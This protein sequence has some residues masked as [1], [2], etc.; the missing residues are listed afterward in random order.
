M[1]A[2]LSGDLDK[3]GGPGILGCLR[4]N[5]SPHGQGE[6]FVRGLAQQAEASPMMTAEKGRLTGC[7]GI[8]MH[9]ADLRHFARFFRLLGMIAYEDDPIGHVFYDRL[10]VQPLPPIDAQVLQRPSRGME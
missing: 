2:N 3:T 5:F 4:M 7:F 6:T 8:L 9:G 10:F 1:T